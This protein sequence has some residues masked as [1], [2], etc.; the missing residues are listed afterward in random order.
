MFFLLHSVVFLYERKCLSSRP[1]ANRSNTAVGTMKYTRENRIFL[2]THRIPIY[3][4]LYS[5]QHQVC[6]NTVFKMMYSSDYHKLSCFT[7]EYESQWNI[8]SSYKQDIEHSIFPLKSFDIQ[9]N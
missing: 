3:I 4:Y 5:N 1:Y 7:V 9:F 2:K 8:H 6:Y